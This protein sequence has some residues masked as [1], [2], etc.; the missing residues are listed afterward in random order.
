MF[1]AGILVLSDKGAKGE[2]EDKSGQV[3]KEMISS[4]G[5]EVVAYEVLPDEKE[6]IVNKLIAWCDQLG[7]DIILTSGGTG[8]SPRDVT[9]EAT[10]EVVE[11]TIP[12]IGEAMRAYGLQKTPRAMLSRGISGIRKKTLI[13][14]LPGSVKG[15]RESLEAVIP[16]LDHALETLQGRANECG[17]A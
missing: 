6:L 13:I 4:I 1:K 3:I 15:A 16:A 7:L 17:Q 2:R 8:L 14:N 10:A 11:R 5:A 9:P 12:G